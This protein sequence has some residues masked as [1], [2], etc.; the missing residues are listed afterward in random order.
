MASLDALS[1]HQLNLQGSFAPMGQQALQAMQ[2][3]QMAQLQ[4]LQ[5]LGMH[6][7]VE[8]V[9][10]S[11][12][13]FHDFAFGE[14]AR[15]IEAIRNKA[16]AL[17]MAN[18]IMPITEVGVMQN[19]PLDMVQYIMAVPEIAQMHN[20][21]ELNGYSGRWDNPQPNYFAEDNHAYR[22]MMNGMI[23]RVEEDDSVYHKATTFVEPI[24]H[25]HELTFRNR[26]DIHQTMLN[27]I[28]MVENGVVD[29]TSENN[30]LI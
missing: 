8:I 16:G 24:K 9:Q 2:Q 18:E 10:G 15:K 3:V 22:N 19:A 27:V 20:N 28:S 12:E 7:A 4:Q 30:D 11:M 23:Q 6:S 13:R 21:G 1:P 26:T 25:Q 29:P 14:T 5:Q 17:F